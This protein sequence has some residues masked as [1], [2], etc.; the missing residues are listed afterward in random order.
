M[1]KV[2]F[3]KLSIGEIV[4]N[5]YRAST[6]FKDAGIDFCCGGKQSLTDACNEKGLIK[7]NLIKELVLLND[8]PFDSSRNYKAWSPDF[9]CDYIVVTH[10][11][12]L[13]EKMPQLVFYTNK[14]SDVHGDHHP[15]LVKVSNLFNNIS[16]ELTQH[17]KNEEEVFF[18]AIKDL[19]SSKSPD[20]KTIVTN[21]M[22]RLLTEHEFAG[23]AMD[24]I[25]SIT[26]GYKIPEDACNTYVVTFKLLQ[27][28][29]DD[30]HTHVHLENNVLFPKVSEL[31]Q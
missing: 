28:F 27:E 7:D 3:E 5:D 29:E 25:N 8:K 21:E 18:P 24:E 2:E 9:L 30:L 26:N 16:D 14:I 6:V 19:I 11:T 17:L 1:D 4:A 13:T 12:Y 10:H 22:S 31:L 23:D 15:E 20:S